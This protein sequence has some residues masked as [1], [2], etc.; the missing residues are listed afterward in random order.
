M[1]V[2]VNFALLFLLLAV[3]V[4]FATDHVV[5]DDGGWT[6]S[7]DYTTWSSGKTFAVGDNLGEFLGVK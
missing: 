2:A 6:Q 4:A 1:A 5:G 3:P 7:G